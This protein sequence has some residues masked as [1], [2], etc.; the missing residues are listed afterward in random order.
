[1]SL[2]YNA[3]SWSSEEATILTALSTRG[4]FA[5]TA[6]KQQI[7]YFHFSLLFPVPDFWHHGQ[8][9]FSAL[10]CLNVISNKAGKWTD[11]VTFCFVSGFCLENRV[12]SR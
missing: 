9:S 3:V 6:L 10:C 7:G 1:M 2:I 12:F 11:A 8:T 4:H 5:V